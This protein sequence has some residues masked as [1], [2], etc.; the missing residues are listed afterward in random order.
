MNTWRSHTFCSKGWFTKSTCVSHLKHYTKWITCAYKHQILQSSPESVVHMISVISVTVPPH[1]HQSYHPMII[2]N[3]LG[4][5]HL[6]AR[7][8]TVPLQLTKFGSPQH[9][10]QEQAL[11]NHVRL[12]RPW[13]RWSGWACLRKDHQIQIPGVLVIPK[14]CIWLWVS[15]Q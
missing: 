4:H 11:Y 7:H 6:T 9:Q 1:D 15:F 5:R 10:K 8:L 13:R 2:S 14:W 12:I 3:I